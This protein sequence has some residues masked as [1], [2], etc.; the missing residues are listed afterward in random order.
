MTFYN[1]LDEMQSLCLRAA[2]ALSVIKPDDPVIYDVYSAAEEGFFKKKQ[3]C[4]VA[5]AG[6]PAG[7]VKTARLERFEKT[8]LE[9]EE[10]AAYKI[11][12]N[13]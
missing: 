4:L 12:E 2:K 3:N 11:R 6:T 10:A 1:Y 7:E 8:V 9:W 13:E 5:D